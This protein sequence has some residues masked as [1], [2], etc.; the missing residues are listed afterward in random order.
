MS[1]PAAFAR[2]LNAAWVLVRAD[3]LIPR[4][5]DHIL[6]PSALFA[7]RTLRL[8]AGPRARQ[9]R[10]GERLAHALERLGP[11][12]IKLGQV[13]S[14]RADIFGR[15]FA[16]DLGRLKDQLPAFPTETAKAVV[17]STLDVSL[18][19]LF[20]SFGEPIAAASLAQAHPATMT[21]GRRVAVKVLRPGIER[22]VARDIETLAL[23][24]E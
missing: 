4:E 24:A 20:A 21:D 17:A 18:D 1:R 12:A 7:A 8:L 13:I 22:R 11:A 16:D 3:A 23:A 5:I 2:L 14:T 19:A 9:G 15:T 6:P 10:P